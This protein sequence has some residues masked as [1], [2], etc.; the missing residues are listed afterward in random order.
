MIENM[1]LA[2]ILLSTALLG[3]GEILRTPD[4]R[5]QNLPGYPFQPHYVKVAGKRMHYVDE[6]KGPTILALHGEPSWSYLYRRMIPILAKNNRVIAPDLIGFGR[7]DKLPNKSDYTFDMHLAALK[8]FVEKRNLRNITLICQDWGGLLGLALVGEVPDRFARLVIMNTGLPVGENPG[9]AFM[10][11][12]ALAAQ[13]TD[14][15][16]GRMIAGAMRIVKLT[17]AEIAA[18]DAPFPDARYKAGAHIFPALV[19]IT[20][21]DPAV[22]RMKKAREVLSQWTKPA[23]VMFSDQ[24]AI[25]R[26]GDKMFRALIPSAKN[27]PEIVIQ[28][29]GHFLQDDKGEEIAGHVVEFLKRRPIP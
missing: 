15:P 19:P 22:P 2:L 28:G 29:A 14:M 1:R 7:S 26:G 18:Y 8:A 21:E 23:L 24:D 3:S 10:Q 12:R 20:P 11:W 4:S 27:E 9:P 6:G 17:P 25:T 13:Q 16:V 5:F